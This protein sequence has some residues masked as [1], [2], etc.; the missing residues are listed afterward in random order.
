M[1]P[2]RAGDATEV[3][4]RRAPSLAEAR[5]NPAPRGRGRLEG[6]SVQEVEITSQFPWSLG[7]SCNCQCPPRKMQESCAFRKIHTKRTPDS[8]LPYEE[9][10]SSAL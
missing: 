8:E 3:K 10:D 7:S 4:A 5:G 1:R 6:W 2:H 9:A